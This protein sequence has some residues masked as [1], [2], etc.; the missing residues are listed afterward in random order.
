MWGISSPI[1]DLFAAYFSYLYADGPMDGFFDAFCQ[2]QSAAVMSPDS[3]TT[4]VIIRPL[5]M[6]MRTV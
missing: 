6:R 3:S 4:P 1:F 5:A 2:F